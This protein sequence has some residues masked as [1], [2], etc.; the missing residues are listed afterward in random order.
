MKY[1]TKLCEIAYRHGTDKCPQI[2]H[3]YTP[4]YYSFLKDKNVKKVLELGVYKGASL[5]MWKEFFP[6]AQ[7]Y[8][9]D[10]N[11]DNLITEDRIETFLCD[12]TN[13][14]EL[15]KALQ[16]IGTDIDLFIDD[17]SHVYKDQV[18]TCKALR[19]LL[20][21]ATYIIEDVNRPDTII[22][23]LKGFGVV[24]PKLNNTKRR[25]DRLLV[26]K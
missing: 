15:K 20:K 17:G 4:F 22:R 16:K 2:K 19:P 3:P 14:E 23:L 7:I 8:G 11:E 26:I 18:K 6:N 21:D 25:D 1:E 10:I 12:G 9:I 13:E 5:R 24:I